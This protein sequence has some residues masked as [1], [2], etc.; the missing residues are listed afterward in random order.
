MVGYYNSILINPSPISIKATGDQ[1]AAADVHRRGKIVAT[2]ISIR[3]TGPAW[4]GYFHR[5]VVE[6][7]D[8]ALSRLLPCQRRRKQ[9]RRKRPRRHHQPPVPSTADC[10]AILT[11]CVGRYII[12][13]IYN[14]DYK[15]RGAS[16][17]VK[18]AKG[19]ND[20]RHKP[21]DR[22]L[23]AELRNLRRQNRSACQRQRPAGENRCPVDE[24]Q[25]RDHHTGDDPLHR[26]PPGRRK[27]ALLR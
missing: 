4:Q 19:G 24:A 9:H 20:E 3:L 13:F 25:R 18:D 5:I 6:I 16:A 22:L 23:R 26:L 14:S 8:T 27:D 7:A 21:T 12:Q 17:P 10:T 1:G 11:I 15:F 2:I